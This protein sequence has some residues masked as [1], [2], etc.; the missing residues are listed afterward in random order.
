MTL[1]QPKISII[2]AVKNNKAGLLHTLASIEAQSYPFL[3]YIVIDGGSTD[4]TLEVIKQN[5]GLIT[6]WISEPDKGI[7]DAF[8]KG[9]RLSKGEYINFQGAGDSFYQPNSIAQLFHHASDGA[10]LICGQVART[11]L[12]GEALWVAPRS[13]PKIFDKKA[14]LFKLTLPHQ[15]L[16]THRR[17]FEKWGEFALDV[18]YAM[19]YEILLRA[20]HNFPSTEIYPVI[21]ANWQAGGIGTHQI[22]SVLKEYHH[23]KMRHK[24]ASKLMLKSIHEYNLF[25]LFVKSKLLGREV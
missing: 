15:G 22:K 24:V 1:L 7:S 2:T 12:E 18:K 8:N 21:V 13:I 19:D 25:K 6:H 20:Y 16:F 9:I 3:E 4:G 23:L 14:L 11:S 10:E 17:F 5:E